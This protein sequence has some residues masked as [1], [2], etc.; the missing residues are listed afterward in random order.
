MQLF[1]G[2]FISEMCLFL[3]LVADTFLSCKV[4]SLKYPI[5]YEMTLKVAG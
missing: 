1:F 2:C 3:R 4:Q 5:F